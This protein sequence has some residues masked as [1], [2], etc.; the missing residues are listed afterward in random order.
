MKFFLADINITKNIRTRL[1]LYSLF[2]ILLALFQ[3]SIVPLIEVF[4][5][6]P[7]LLLLFSIWIVLS[8]GKLVGFVA[9]FILGVLYDI[10]TLQVIGVSS[11]AFLV[12]ALIASFFYRKDKEI[13]VLAHYGFIFIVFFSAMSANLIQNIF[14]LRL[15]QIDFWISFVNK[16]LGNTVYTTFLSLIPFYISYRNRK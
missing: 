10:F 7:N 3:I 15:S 9:A 11:F 16:W 8:E 5:S 13:L 4:E 12:S 6:I 14:Y 2:A 1:G